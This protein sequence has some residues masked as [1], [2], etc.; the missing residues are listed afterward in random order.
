MN[1]KKLAAITAISIVAFIFLL[2]AA[3]FG[4]LGF[5]LFTI[6]GDVSVAKAF[7]YGT[8]SSGILSAISLVVAIVA[9]TILVTYRI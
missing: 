4:L 7:V 3:L 8:I 6:L 9:N 2:I 5:G 1:P